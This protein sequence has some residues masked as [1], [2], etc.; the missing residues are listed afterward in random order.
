MI[1]DN[2]SMQMVSRPQ[3][4]D[5]LVTPNLYGNI[6]GNIGAGLIG[7]PG[8]VPGVNMGRD[9]VRRL[10]DLGSGFILLLT[11]FSRWPPQA[12]FEPGTRHSGQ[13]IKGQGIA[14]PTATIF[15]STLM[16]RHLNLSTHADNIVFA[17]KRVIKNGNVRLSA[18]FLH[19]LSFSSPLFLNSLSPLSFFLHSLSPLSFFFFSTLFLFL[20]HSF[21]TLFLRSISHSLTHSSVSH[22]RFSPRTWAA[23]RPLPNLSRRSRPK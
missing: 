9:A 17:L 18:L 22:C 8:V 13:D 1:V 2:A 15:C 16:L 14:N 10:V 21:S 7:G 4:F 23:R 19:S 20:L 11:V 12:L 6:I 5:V 3:Q